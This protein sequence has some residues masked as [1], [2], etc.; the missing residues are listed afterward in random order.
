MHFIFKIQHSGFDLHSYIFFSLLPSLIPDTPPSPTTT[1]NSAF[2]LNNSNG[3]IIKWNGSCSLCI[4][5]A[6]TVVPFSLWTISE[7]QPPCSFSV[8]AGRM[9]GWQANASG[10]LWN[11]PIPPGN[12]CHG[13]ARKTFFSCY[14]FTYAEEGNG[15]VWWVKGR[16]GLWWDFPPHDTAAFSACVNKASLNCLI[17]LCKL[18]DQG[19]YW[20]PPSK[21]SAE[22]VSLAHVFKSFSST[23]TCSFSKLK[24]TLIYSDDV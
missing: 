22:C 2:V 7:S 15:G 18:R 11:K 23:S 5:S 21:R 9:W 24:W 4:H 16:W 13:D 6:L 17:I 14:Q 12:P 3:A 20:K 10:E 19:T 1:S 8:A